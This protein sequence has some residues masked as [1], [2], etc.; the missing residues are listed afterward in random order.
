[1]ISGEGVVFFGVAESKF[2]MVHL[3]MAPMGMGEF[4]WMPSFLGSM[5]KTWVG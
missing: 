5:F 3:T 2:K 1:M 4:F